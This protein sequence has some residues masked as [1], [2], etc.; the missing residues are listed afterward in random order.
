MAKA[1][2]KEEAVVEE[3]SGSF[4]DK[5][6]EEQFAEAK[7][8]SKVDDTVKYWVDT[9]NWA[10]N[11]IIC[12]KFKG[13][14]PGGRISNLFG[15]SGVGKSMFPA[16]ASKAKDW[17]K[18]DFDQFDRILLIDSEGGGNG[19]GLYKFLD[20][21]LEKT[22]YVDTI[23][24]L[25]SFRVNKKTGKK[26]TVTD[27][28][29]P[30]PNK[31]ETDEYIYKIG[32][33]TFLKRFVYA[34][35]YG[36]SKEKI[37]IIVDSISNIKSFK[38]AVDGTE[39]MG[40]TNKLLNNLFGLDN[41]LHEIDATVLLASKVYTNL[42][43]PYDPWVVTGGQS[44]IYNPSCSLQLSSMA[45]SDEISD[46]ESKEEKKRRNETSLG[47]SYKIIRVKVAKSRFGTEGR[48]AWVLL[49][50]TYG[51]VRNSGLFK[52]L[53]DFGAIKKVGNSNKFECP[54]VI[55]GS[56]FKK[57]FAKIFAKNEEEYIDKLQPI[58]DEIEAE[59]KRKRL[60]VNVSDLSEFEEDE[61][62]GAEEA[63]EG[64]IKVGDDLLSPEEIPTED[65]LI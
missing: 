2:K 1:K 42:N 22:R 14:Y 20:A 40:R 49:D 21:P 65:D 50:A 25:D 60:A 47:N 18:I 12:K 48:N 30:A 32:L 7:D 43:N 56:F 28:D 57:D 3:S 4:F 6:I 5:L 15:L 51:L 62:E 10:M 24:T 26:E 35:K 41:D 44:V 55:E 52:L 59:M 33:I 23:T 38:Q 8:L 29:F 13:G 63:L 11:Y 17:E 19:Y 31:T 58:M 34:M 27:K 61:E 46:A 53:F 39:D 36:K 64:M 16:I 37:L 54:G 9:G 45:G